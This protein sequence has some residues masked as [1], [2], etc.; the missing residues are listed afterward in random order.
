MAMKETRAALSCIK[1]ND[2]VFF[3]IPRGKKILLPLSRNDHSL[4]LYECLKRYSM[5]AKKS[6]E[7]VPVCFCF[8]SS[9][10]PIEGYPFLDHLEVEQE[11][12]ARELASRSYESYI[13][14]LK[15]LAYANEAE[16]HGCSLIALPTSFEDFYFHFQDNLF[17]QGKISAFSPYSPAA[18]GLCFIRPLLSFSEKDM[19]GG[20]EELGIKAKGKVRDCPLGK[21][22]KD[23]FLKATCYGEARPNLP[24]SKKREAL[25][26]C[27]DLYFAS[28]GETMLVK[29]Q[30]ASEVASFR[31]SELDAHRIRLF[32][33]RFDESANQA[34]ILSSFR[35]YWKSKRK[36]PIQFFI[37]A[38]E[39]LKLDDDWKAVG[40]YFTMKTW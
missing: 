28:E 25:E 1:K 35:F 19:K 37:P 39:K 22:E 20:E 24:V 21:K 6:F 23:A 34:K 26:D 10:K 9:D 30:D 7:I 4:F 40:G 27:P 38:T 12:I 33:F 31:I 32:S 16:A 17:L 15:R 3:L 2:D 18:H 11:R 13:A 5:Y 36:A 14:K 29:S 8:E